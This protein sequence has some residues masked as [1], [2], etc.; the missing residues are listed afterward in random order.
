MSH[1]DYKFPPSAREGAVPRPG[2]VQQLLDPF[3]P[4][5]T[6][7][8]LILGLRGG[9]GEGGKELREQNAK[10]VM[11]WEK[12]RTVDY[13]TSPEAVKKDQAWYDEQL[14]NQRRSK[15]Y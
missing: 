9:W 12:L 7:S 14:Q 10:D 5:S 11:R 13:I 2:F 1:N 4:Q 6:V 15:G 3:Y 8:Q